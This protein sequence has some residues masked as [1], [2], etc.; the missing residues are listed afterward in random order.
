MESYLPLIN[1]ER[2]ARQDMGIAWLKSLQLVSLLASRIKGIALIRQVGR[3]VIYSLH[4]I[5]ARF[6]LL[7]EA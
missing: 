2:E 3:T 1:L 7:S 5:F 4:G 6:P